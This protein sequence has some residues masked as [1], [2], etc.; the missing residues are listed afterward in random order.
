MQH[1]S[2]D[3]G[4]TRPGSERGAS[5]VEFA[6]ILPLLIMLLFGIIT[7]GQAYNLNNSLNNAARESARYAATLPVDA[8]MTIYLNSV[9]DVARTSATGAM[10]PSAPGQRICVA[11]VYPD[12]SA[13]DDRTTRLIETSGARVIDVGTPCISDGRPS[14]ERRV[15]VAVQRD[16]ELEAVLYSQTLHLDASSVARYERIDI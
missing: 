13:S 16:S 14:D 5:V 12:G 10:D 1:N 8:N 9:A 11:Y 6:I 4:G 7:G 3:S 15:Q 2:I